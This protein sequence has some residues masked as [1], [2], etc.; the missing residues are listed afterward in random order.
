MSYNLYYKGS[1]KTVSVDKD[2]AYART[3]PEIA[4]VN[5]IFTLMAVTSSF[6]FVYMSIY[7]YKK[8]CFAAAVVW[9]LLQNLDT[10]ILFISLSINP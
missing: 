5:N 9:D 1:D 6:Y 4:I 10:V 8:L 7:L 2:L 3:C